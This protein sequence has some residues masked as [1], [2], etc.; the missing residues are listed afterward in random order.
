MDETLETMR[1]I[2]FFLCALAFLPQI[3]VGQQVTAL[4]KPVVEVGRDVVPGRDRLKLVIKERRVTRD[5]FVKLHQATF[6]RLGPQ[7]GRWEGTV[8]GQGRVVLRLRLL[9]AGKIVSEHRVGSVD[10]RSKEKPVPFFFEARVPS[11]S[12]WEWKVLTQIT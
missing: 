11:D 1:E 8:S 3:A 7:L 9:R 10:M 4:E 6:K 12:G 5:A 2:L